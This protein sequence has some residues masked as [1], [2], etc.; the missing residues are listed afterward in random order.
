MPMNEPLVSIGIPTYNNPEG[1]ENTIFNFLCQSYENFEIIV[2]VNPSLDEDINNKYRKLSERYKG[3]KWHFQNN[4]TGLINNFEFVLQQATGKY[5]MYAQDDDEWSLGFI[6]GLVSL[7]EDNPLVPVAMSVVQRR[8]DTGK[9]FD[10]FDMKNISVLNAMHDEKLA[11]VFMGV[12]RIN[13]LREYSTDQT[14]IAIDAQ[15]IL[16]GGVMINPH[17]LYTKGMRHDKAKEQIKNNPFWYFHIY[18]SLLKGV[19]RIDKMKVP[20][21]AVYNFVWVI[22]SYA[23]QILFLLPVDHPIRKTVRKLTSHS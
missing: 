18:W 3:I 16:D 20:V 14:D 17:E 4:N 23:A 2:S 1:L 10:T 6:N 8:D 21:V 19:Y 12:W 22:R 13:K 9:I 15:A 5:F 7:L 11:F